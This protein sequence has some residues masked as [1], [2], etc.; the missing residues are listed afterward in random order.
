MP[1]KNMIPKG[2]RRQSVRAEYRLHRDAVREQAGSG[3]APHIE[4]TSS[5]ESQEPQPV[6]PVPDIVAEVLPGLELDHLQPGVRTFLAERGAR[7]LRLDAFLSR[8]LSDVSRSRIQTLIT[9][10]QVTVQEK[11]VPASTHLK[12]GERIEVTGEPLL[13]P[14][15]GKPEDIPLSILYEDDDLAVIDKAAG[16]M[17]HSGSGSAEHNGGTLV[18]ALLFHFGKGLSGVGGELRPGIVHRLDKDTSGLILVA[19]N[20]RAHQRLSE[21]FSSRTLC[22]TYLALVHG[23]LEENEGTV[24][25]PISR[26]LVRRTRMT[27][28]RAAGRHAITHWQ[29]RERLNGA[30]GRFTLLE[31][32]IE[33]GRTHQIRVHMQA[34][35]RPVV[36]DKTYGAPETL[37]PKPGKADPDSESIRLERNFLHAAEL[38]FRH[39]VSDKALT[40]S[41][42]LP[43]DLEELLSRLRAG[44]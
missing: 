42:P 33:T 26:D 12:G 20:D 1:S 16:M 41:S 36:G 23:A 2:K 19:K 22:K 17:V 10:G 25:L 27:T 15:H 11:V 4:G 7:D 6:L 34:L 5:R 13:P 32:H 14:I 31:L 18:N 39:P 9:A 35:G 38:Q 40:L 3:S 24:D 43:A 8:M 21:Q 44:G 30:F 37:R 29:V 28:R